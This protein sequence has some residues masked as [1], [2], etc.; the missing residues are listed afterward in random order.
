[1]AA[2]RKDLLEKDIHRLIK[3]FLCSDHFEDD[4]FEDPVRR[5]KLIKTKRPVKVPLPTIFRCNFDEVVPKNLNRLSSDSYAIRIANFQSDDVLEVVVEDEDPRQGTLIRTKGSIPITEQKSTEITVISAEDVMEEEDLV[6]EIY[7]ST[8]TC[9]LCGCTYKYPSEETFHSI[10]D[11]VE[12]VNLLNIVMPGEIV[13]DN[14]MPE[15]CCSGCK[16]DLVT[17]ANIV[18]RFRTTQDKFLAN[19]TIS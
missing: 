15:L 1:M 10:F 2:G 16:V 6:T 18:T 3:Y 19:E 9:R 14:N 17:A 13:E 5:D 11:N 4:C 12:L 8:D 7:A